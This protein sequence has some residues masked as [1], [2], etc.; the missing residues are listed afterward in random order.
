MTDH[1][2]PLRPTLRG[3]DGLIEDTRTPAQRAADRLAETRQLAEAAARH[4]VEA[5][6][7]AAHQCAEVAALGDALKPG[8]RDGFGQ[9]AAMAANFARKLEGLV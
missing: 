6:A 1:I 4:A 8:G 5:L 9:A 2:T 3:H 7:E